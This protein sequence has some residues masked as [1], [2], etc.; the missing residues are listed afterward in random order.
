M[1][2]LLAL[3]Q[4]KAPI[5]VDVAKQPPPPTPSI[6]YGSVLL[7]AVGLVGAILAAS[8]IVAGARSAGLVARALSFRPLVFIGRISYG[9]YLWHPFFT[10]VLNVPPSGALPLTFGAATASY[11]TIERAFLSRRVEP[12]PIGAVLT[13]ARA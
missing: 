3:L 7:S 11:Y 13:P 8:F 2:F 9:L 12:A 6:S 4:E 5:V 1:L 10:S